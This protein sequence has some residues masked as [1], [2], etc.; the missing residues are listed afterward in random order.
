MLHKRNKSEEKLS[1]TIGDFINQD[2]IKPKFYQAGIS[3]IWKELMGEMVAGYTSSIKVS[4]NKLI[5]VITSGPL[6]H[7]LAYNKE[8]LINKINEKM[9]EDYIKEIIIR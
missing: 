5:L 8:K 1:D 9:G 7:E 6:K 4:G 2:K 3:S